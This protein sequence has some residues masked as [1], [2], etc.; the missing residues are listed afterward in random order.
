M[1]NILRKQVR[2]AD[3]IPVRGAVV[4][5]L[6]SGRIIVVNVQFVFR[7]NLKASYTRCV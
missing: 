1:V 3:F 6:V 7:M 5:W 4:V 2:M